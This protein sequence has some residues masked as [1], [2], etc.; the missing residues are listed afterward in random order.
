MDFD[1]NA[2]ARDARI[3]TDVAIAVETYVDEITILFPIEANFAVTRRR[4]L[5][6]GRPDRD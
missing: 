2:R 3:V 4:D 5:R 1:I 6:D